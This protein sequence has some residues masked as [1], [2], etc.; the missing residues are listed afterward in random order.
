MDSWRELFTATDLAHKLRRQHVVTFPG[1]PLTGDLTALTSRYFTEI[2]IGGAIIGLLQPTRRLQIVGGGLIER[3]AWFDELMLGLGPAV[4]LLDLQSVSE[5]RQAGIAAGLQRLIGEDLRQVAFAAE[6]GADVDD[7]VAE[8][9]HRLTGLAEAADAR[10]NATASHLTRSRLKQASIWG[11]NGLLLGAL[12][13]GILTGIASGGIL[14]PTAILAGVGFALG[15]VAGATGPTKT[16]TAGPDPVV[17]ELLTHL[18]A[19]RKF[20]SAQ[21]NL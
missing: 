16:P 2:P 14:L 11:G 1:D 6:R 13:G 7:A 15:A 8:A 21:Q 10:I 5:L 18:R 4:N 3:G 12:G 20:E 17:F 19:K 9:K